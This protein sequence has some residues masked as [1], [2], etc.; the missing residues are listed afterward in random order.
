MLYYNKYLKYKQKYLEL[1]K[2]SGG[3]SRR[4]RRTTNIAGVANVTG[5]ADIADIDDGAG[6]ADRRGSQH[7]TGV[8]DRRGSQPVTGIA[9]RRGSQPVTGVADRR[10]S[11]HV[12]GVADRRGSQPVTGVADRRGS[13][14]VTGVADRRGS[15]H[16]TGVADRRG[17][18]PVTGVADR[19]GSQPVT[20]VADRRGSQPVT[21]VADRRTSNI[22]S[23]DVVN[24]QTAKY[25]GDTGNCNHIPINDECILSADQNATL[26]ILINDFLRQTE[27]NILTNINFSDIICDNCND[28]YKKNNYSKYFSDH[29]IL[30]CYNDSTNILIITFNV[31]TNKIMERNI[32]KYFYNNHNHIKI[33]KI[34][35]SIDVKDIQKKISYFKLL[36][37]IRYVYKF[38]IYIIFSIRII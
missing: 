17:S 30:T 31:E 3:S 6:V 18:Q 23:V 5:V 16:V 19:R 21:G 4:N 22:T 1:K 20:G 37:Y 24:R 13:Q 33:D 10:G 38:L 35:Q 12:T 7:V 32:K 11:Q 9:D 8:A 2:I 29:P 27:Q 26:L 25:I 15:Q 28:K 34:A 36:F 14:P